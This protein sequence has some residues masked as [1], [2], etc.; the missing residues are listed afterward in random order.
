MKKTLCFV[1][2]V[3][4]CL[5]LTACGLPG[6]GYLITM[7]SETGD[8]L[9][10]ERA[11][12][13]ELV[14]L[15]SAR[16]GYTVGA[17]YVNGRRIE[18]DSFV[19]PQSDV[20]A[21]VVLE[22]EA[23]DAH[24]VTV[25]ESG[26]FGRTVADLSR[27]R[28]GDTVTLT[29][30]AS[31]ANRV[32]EYLVNGQTIGGNSFTMPDEDV[33]VTVR[34]EQMFRPGEL[35]LSATQSYEKAT[36]HWYAGYSENGLTVEAVVQDNILF[37]DTRF[38]G[39]IAYGDNIEF[40]I[41]PRTSATGL[42]GT[43]YKVLVGADGSFL[44]DRYQGG[45][46]VSA[47]NSGIT[48][49]TR[50]CEQSS[51]G[52]NGYWVNVFLPYSLFGNAGMAGT[53]TIAPA[54]R[55]T[56]NALKTVWAAYT[57]MR[58]S[59]GDAKTHILVDTDGTF[60]ASDVKGGNLFVGDGLLSQSFWGNFFDN[61]DG[62]GSVYS[63]ASSGADAAYWS[64][65]I[66]LISDRA[67]EHIYFSSGV[68]EN[69]VLSTFSDIREFTQRLQAAMPD[70]ALTFITP[71]PSL[72]GDPAKAEALSGMM[73][74]WLASENIP[75]IDLCAAVCQSGVPNRNLY[76]SSVT[77]S[78]EGY[79]LLGKL[80]RLDRGV[81]PDRG[82]AEWGDCGCFVATGDWT[83]SAGVLR[84][85]S[86]ITR[87]VYYRTPLEGDFEFSLTLSAGTV[88]NGDAYPKFGFTLQDETR[89]YCF[90]LNGENGLTGTRAG[91]VPYTL[92]QFDWANSSETDVPGLTYTGSNGA[93]L[94]L[95][96]EGGTIAF[97][98]NDTQVFAG[99]LGYSKQVTV[100]LFSF[101]TAL[102][103]RNWTIEGGRS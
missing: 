12:A 78:E 3:A 43:R 64:E 89:A 8:V 4:L 60:R 92:G 14:T 57:G 67:P 46:W 53:L 87:K 59:F 5:S 40:I 2:F 72:A 74:E 102:D 29:T 98:V 6:S 33:V 41:G 56:L 90:Y 58:C 54:M 51:H 32:Q 82:N 71:I 15:R 52:F 39:T 42:D 7:Q 48:V 96:R 17:V 38:L 103:I 91:I 86:D 79:A 31:Y 18:G 49:S 61:L 19:M 13:G 73:R 50:P 97:Y 84:L 25:S 77:L 68:S 66:P 34:Y 45:S 24:T 75:C 83:E 37:T 62:M 36:S 65:N 21:L 55:N 69:S 95:K 9:G 35:V 27:A 100:G 88:Y 101:N 10:S 23:E 11:D 93:L 81:Y 85:R 63:I 26:E 47:G 1:L 22:S 70:T 44:F 76:A 94:R 80:I 16:R 30:Y 20:T 28:E 99:T